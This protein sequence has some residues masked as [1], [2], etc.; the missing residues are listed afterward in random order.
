MKRPL[1]EKLEAL[2]DHLFLLR[3][4]R[5]NGQRD[6]ARFK[7]LAS[8]LRLLICKSSG[9]EDLLWRLTR[10]MGVDER[11][12]VHV[13]GTVNLLNPLAKGLQFLFMPLLRAGAGHPSVPV[14]HV[15]FRKLVKQSPAIF[16]DGEHL[17][18][19]KII[20]LV[21]NQIGSSH[22]AD[23]LNPKLQFL[24]RNLFINN[25]PSFFDILARDAEFTLEIGERVIS[26]A[27]AAFSFKRKSRS[28][29]GY[30]DLSITIRLQL[31]HSVKEPICVATFESAVSNINVQIIMTETAI[32]YQFTKLAVAV[33]AVEAPLPA[34][35]A[36]GTSA[37]FCI[38][39]SSAHQQARAIINDVP[40]QEVELPL[41]FVDVREMVPM[42]TPETSVLLKEFI[43]GHERLL[44]PDEVGRLAEGKPPY[45]G[46]ILKPGDAKDPVFPP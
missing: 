32:R 34:G 29:E 27:E 6:D 25:R 12:H 9:T 30:G 13:P 5:H 24:R 28:R 21:A 42:P 41:G 2:D 18:H 8:E 11:V 39:Y 15:S 31:K 43:A 33:G 45:F 10:E 14:G 44:R 37:A 20:G 1:A 38:S 16:V 17:T 46:R 23:N 4:A 22:E 3:D 35:W 36:P 40:M 19:Q 7:V 26:R